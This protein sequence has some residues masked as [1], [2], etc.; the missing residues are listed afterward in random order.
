MSTATDYRGAGAAVPPI[1]E[2][3]HPHEQSRFGLA[4]FAA[5]GFLFLL[6]VVVAASGAGALIGAIALLAVVVGSVWIGLQLARARLVGRSVRVTP[7]TFPEVQGA[8]DAVRLQL[9]YRR[10]IEVFVTEKGDPPISCT[11]YLSTRIILIQGDF[12]AGLLDAPKRPQLTFLLAR[13]IGAL[14]SRHSRLEG[15]LLVLAAANALQFVKIFI[16]PYYRATAYSGDQI[17]LACCGSLEAALQATGRLLVGKE[18]A[19]GLPLGGFLPQAV[20]VRTGALTR[21]VQLFADEPH[22][23][24]RYVNLLAFAHARQPETV[25]RLRGTLDPVGVQHLDHVCATSVHLRPAYGQAPSYP[26]PSGP[27]AAPPAAPRLADYPPPTAAPVQRDQSTAERPR[28]HLDYPPPR[29]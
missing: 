9:D 14:K 1:N 5:G 20:A 16:T 26:P 29:P 22:V 25:Q 8:L 15:A 24:S 17:G 28:P 4:L 19:G 13:E 2:L 3:L 21:W 6:F 11:T 10:P 7:E 27:P 18:L 12:V 23:T